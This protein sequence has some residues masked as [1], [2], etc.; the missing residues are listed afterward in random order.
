[1]FQEHPF[2]AEITFDDLDVPAF[3]RAWSFLE[4]PTKEMSIDEACALFDTF[5]AYGFHHCIQKRNKVFIN[6]VRKINDKWRVSKRSMEGLGLSY[7]AEK[8]EVHSSVDRLIWMAQTCHKTG[9]KCTKLIICLLAKLLCHPEK[10]VLF[11]QEQVEKIAPLMPFYPVLIEP[12]GLT[13]D[14]IDNPLFAAMLQSKLAE[15]EILEALVR[16]CKTL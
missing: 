15:R 9:A 1:M 7:D 5:E 3:L 14:M 12:F 13:A 4:D 2:E 6:Y 11:S 16:K 8:R 10:A